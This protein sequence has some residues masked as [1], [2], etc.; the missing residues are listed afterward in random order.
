MDQLIEPYIQVSFGIPS[1]TESCALTKVASDNVFGRDVN[2]NTN[3][4]DHEVTVQD[5]EKTSASGNTVKLFV[6]DFLASPI[7]DD[8]W[9]KALREAFKSRVVLRGM[10][11]EGDDSFRIQGLDGV[12]VES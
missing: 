6:E 9:T 8:E 2:Y 3:I 10:E 12:D 4:C 11:R 7:F 1:E 5:I